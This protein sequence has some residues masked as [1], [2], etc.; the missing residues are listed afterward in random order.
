[1]HPAQTESRYGLEILRRPL[2]G[3]MC[4][5]V[6]VAEQCSEP[7]PFFGASC[8]VSELFCVGCDCDEA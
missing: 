1:M 7:V 8:K 4:A 2:D 5:T 6:E 3:T